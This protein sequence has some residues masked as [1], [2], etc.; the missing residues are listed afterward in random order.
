MKYI[1][2]IFL[3]PCL[4]FCCCTSWNQRSAVQ[5]DSV[6]V[7]GIVYEGTAQGYRGPVT[8]QVRLNGGNIS[9]I[10]IVDSVEDRFVGGAAMEELIGIIIENNSTDVDAVSGATESSRGFLEAVQNAILRL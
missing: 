3:F 9:E 2:F 4:G 8:V 10:I 1:L 5:N 6:G 7:S